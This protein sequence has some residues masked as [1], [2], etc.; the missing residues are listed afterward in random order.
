[1]KENL[2]I[3]ESYI[4]KTQNYCYG[5]SEFYET[6]YNNL[7]DLYKFLVKEFGRCTGKMFIDT[8][9]GKTRQTGWVFIKKVKYEDCNEHYLQEVWVEVSKT[10]PYK[11]QVLENLNYLFN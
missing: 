6:R 7:S 11:K 4:N 10:K 2:F 1:M 8:K 5:E 3:N 9:E